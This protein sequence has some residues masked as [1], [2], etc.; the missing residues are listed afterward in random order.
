MA[1][2]NF[3]NLSISVSNSGS[4]SDSDSDSTVKAGSVADSD[5]TVKAESGAKPNST[6]RLGMWLGTKI[7]VAPSYRPRPD[8]N[9]TTTRACS[10]TLPIPVMASVSTSLSR[11]A[12][13]PTAMPKAPSAPPA[14]LSKAEQLFN[15]I[16]LYFYNEVRPLCTQ[17]LHN[18]PS[19]KRAFK[20][21]YEELS[22]ALGMRTRRVVS[23]SR[24]LGHS[25]LNER[26]LTER[27]ED[28]PLMT[29]DEVRTMDLDQVVRDLEG[30]SGVVE[31][32]DLHVWT[33]TSGMIAMSA[34]AIVREAEQ[35]QQVL[36]RIN[37]AMRAMGIGHV[38]LQ[39]ERLEMEECELTLHP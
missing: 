13:T 20:T 10:P 29:M 23:K 4:V 27:S 25:Q 1:P 14:E 9:P 6:H 18:P 15:M 7:P 19:E 31:V 34:H 35:H 37:D 17:F 22:D 8:F 36:E 11:V 16:H 32:H 39:L 12:S 30:V 26:T 28:A 3:K 24:P 21:Q 2:R 38:T 33:V 5:S